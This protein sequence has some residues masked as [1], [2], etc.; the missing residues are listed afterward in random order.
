PEPPEKIRRYK[1]LNF[2][3]RWLSLR[4]VATPV[5]EIMF[6]QK[7]MADPE[8][9][10]LREEWR[11]RLLANDRIGI[12]RAVKGV[13]HRAGVNDQLEAITVPTLIIVGDQ[14]VTLEPAESESMHA[15]IPDSRLVII[16][17]AGHTSTVEEPEAVNAAISE[18]L[19]GLD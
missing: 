7:F 4:L 5:M 1:L 15:S 9:A 10:E 8:R 17:G 12:T 19:A 13:I 6:G 14:D 2:V 18:F 3:A 16:P 11:R